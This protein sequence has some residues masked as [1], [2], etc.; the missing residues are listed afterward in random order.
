MQSFFKR[1]NIFPTLLL[2][3]VSI[4]PLPAFADGLTSYQESIFVQAAQISQ[5]LNQNCQNCSYA[6]TPQA[7]SA[8]N[9]VYGRAFL[10]PVVSIHVAFGYMDISEGVPTIYG[11][12]Q[13]SPGQSVDGYAEEAFMTEIQK[14]CYTSAGACGF[15][16]QGP[17]S[18]VFIKSAKL[19]GKSVTLKIETTHAS[20]T[21]DLMTNLGPQ[22]KL[23]TAQTFISE[24]NFF[25]SIATSDLTIYTGHARA[26]GGPDFHPPVL[27][28]DGTPNYGGYYLA[29][30]PGINH[31]IKSLKESPRHPAL[32][33]LLGCNTDKLFRKQIIAT[34]SK[35]GLVT[36]NDLTE[37]EAVFRATY[38]I[39]DGFLKRQCGPTLKM[40]VNQFSAQTGSQAVLTHFP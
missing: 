32:L 7:D 28:Q 6:G 26:G 29:N 1:L 12:Y 16:P 19:N 36:L 24:L 8:C 4:G 9:T 13:F 31:L 11:G 33:A 3:A 39:T 21:P 23:Q 27:K 14:P 20:A 34:D 10:K 25:G 30:H 40:V 15:R 17:G 38:L 2:A 22:A 35:M 5:N 18:N 37:F